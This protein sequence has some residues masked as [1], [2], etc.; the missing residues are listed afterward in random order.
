MLRLRLE[1][2]SNEP[3]E[4]D[5]LFGYRWGGATGYNSRTLLPSLLDALPGNGEYPWNGAAGFSQIEATFTPSQGAN[6]SM[7]GEWETVPESWDTAP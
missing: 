7:E 5:R 6:P 4:D 1:V 2:K 3:L